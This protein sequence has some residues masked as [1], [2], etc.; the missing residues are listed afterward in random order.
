MHNFMQR[1]WTYDRM[2]LSIIDYNIDNKNN[3]KYRVQVQSTK[4]TYKVLL[5]YNY[6]YNRPWALLIAS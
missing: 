1:C 6:N 5:Y 3:D 4:Y 2:R